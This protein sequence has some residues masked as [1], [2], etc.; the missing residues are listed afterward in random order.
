MATLPETITIQHQEPRPCWVKGRRAIFHRWTDTARAIVPHG[1]PEIETDVRFQLWNVHGLVE[2]E[3]GTVERV[4]PQDIQFPKHSIFRDYDWD[5]MEH[6]RDQAAEGEPLQVERELE[7]LLQESET[8]KAP[9]DIEMLRTMHNLAK[10][11]NP[12]ERVTTAA[13]ET[14]TVPTPAT[15]RN[16]GLIGWLNGFKRAAANHEEIMAD[17][18]K[19]RGL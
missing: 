11:I 7:Q 16:Y 1:L 9:A 14:R 17:A 13:P 12:L 6:E 19:E 8:E 5:A 18:E 15:E 3:D 10:K 4:W 2:Y